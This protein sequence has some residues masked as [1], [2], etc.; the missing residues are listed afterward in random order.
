MSL[1]VSDEES[2]VACVCEVEP[3]SPG[4]AK[5]TKGCYKLEQGGKTIRGPVAD[6]W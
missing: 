3:E 6:S 4:G 2:H 1:H 5:R